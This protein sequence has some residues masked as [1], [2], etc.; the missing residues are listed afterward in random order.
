MEKA[1]RAASAQ[2]SVAAE[3]YRPAWLGA[4]CT[5]LM[6]PKPDGSLPSKMKAPKNA[7]PLAQPDARAMVAEFIHQQEWTLK[8]L[9]AAGSVNLA[10][11]RVPTSLSPWLRLEL[12]ATFSFVIAHTERHIL[13]A[14]RA[15]A[16]QRQG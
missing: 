12:G 10:Q 2:G 6:R 3:A 4:Y 14:E 7:V 8:L 16:L 1:I 15:L 13:Q 11:V 5:R 9:E